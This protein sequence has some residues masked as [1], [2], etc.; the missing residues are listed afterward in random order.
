[1]L[2]QDESGNV[3]LTISNQSLAT[4]LVD[5]EI[6]IDGRMAISED[7]D[8]MGGGLPQHNWRVFR[9]QLERGSHTIAVSS[10][11]GGAR[12]ESEVEVTGR[13]TATIAY[14]HEP[15]KL[16]QGSERFFTL[17][18]SEQPVAYL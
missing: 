1:M 6:T 10:V 12:L 15:G 13:H 18:F 2:P 3:A 7:F 8:V 16:Y 11:K 9:F 14:W 4:P 17:A 5:I